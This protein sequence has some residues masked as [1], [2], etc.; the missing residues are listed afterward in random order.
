MKLIKQEEV[1]R[2]GILSSWNVPQL[3]NQLRAGVEFAEKEIIK[4]I[5]AIIIENQGLKLFK[6]RQEVLLPNGLTSWYETF[7]EIASSIEYIIHYTGITPDHPIVNY[8][9]D[10]GSGAMYELAKDW[11]NEFEAKY[12]DTIWG[13]DLDWLDTLN[14]FFVTKAKS[15]WLM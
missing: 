2:A 12:K 15:L 8:Y 13:E 14:E 6:D 3:Y 10:N 1:D 7:Y 4:H 9:Q 5:E 11:T